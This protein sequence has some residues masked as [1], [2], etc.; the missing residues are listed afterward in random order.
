MF[1]KEYTIAMNQ[2]QKKVNQPLALLA[3]APHIQRQW[4][5]SWRRW[6][7]FKKWDLSFLYYPSFCCPT[8]VLIQYHCSHWQGHNQVFKTLQSLQQCLAFDKLSSVVTKY[9][10]IRGIWLLL[11]KQACVL[12]QERTWLFCPFHSHIHESYN[13][14]LDTPPEPKN[15]PPTGFSSFS[16]LLTMFKESIKNT[17]NIVTR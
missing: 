4:S 7:K 1:N 13:T 16:S 17:S 11:D 8:S 15:P 3:A 9:L 12:S 14:L 6:G 10:H 5:S 2:K